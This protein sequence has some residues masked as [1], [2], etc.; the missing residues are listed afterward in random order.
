MRAP[1]EPGSGGAG[2]GSR[3]NRGGAVGHA[4]AAVVGPRDGFQLLEADGLTLVH[5]GLITTLLTG[6]PAGWPAFRPG[7]LG[8]GR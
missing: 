4:V 1:S 8:L 5:L 6:L 2:L 3:M 7:W